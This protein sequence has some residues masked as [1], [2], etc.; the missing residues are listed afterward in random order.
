MFKRVIYKV[1]IFPIRKIRLLKKNVHFGYNVSV[2]EL[3]Q[4]EGEN[5]I[6]QNSKLINTKLGYGS[7]VSH[8]T[9]LANVDVGKYSSIGPNIH[10][11]SGQHP[12]K[13][14]VSTHP[15]FFSIRPSGGFTYSK[16]QLFEEKKYVDKENDIQVQIGN[17][18]WI[19]DSALIME[20]VIIGDGAI[21]ASGTLVNKNVPNYAIVGGVPAKIIRYR[22][23]YK[24]IQYLNH[25]KWWDKSN[26]WLS[27]NSY[28]FENI[29]NFINH[30]RP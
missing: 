13:R 15:A 30:T 27:D 10:V 28:L 23:N 6:S 12:T 8:S 16:K 25:F 29:E 11:I 21:I 7:Y 17:D 1:F 5:I 19:G 9:N 18:V 4:F 24:Q 20:G 14:Y 3:S 2:D 26:E 22:F